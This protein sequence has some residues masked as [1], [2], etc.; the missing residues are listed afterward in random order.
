MWDV[1]ALD[2]RVAHVEGA[3]REEVRLSI[4]PRFELRRKPNLVQRAS[5]NCILVRYALVTSC[6]LL[7]RCARTCA[8]TETGKSTGDWKCDEV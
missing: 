3:H 6:L 1:A 7:R 8:R 5:L 4:G 2:R